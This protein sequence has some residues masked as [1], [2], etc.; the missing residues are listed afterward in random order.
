MEVGD[1]FYLPRK[2]IEDRGFAYK[3]AIYFGPYGLDVGEILNEYVK[4]EITHIKPK[5]QNSYAKIIYNNIKGLCYVEDLFVWF[6][7][8]D[9]L[10]TKEDVINIKR[11]KLEEE[12]K[13]AKEL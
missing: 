4:I 3:Y 2:I 9:K 8:E 13:N 5:G 6:N 12:L 11:Q 7:E 10:L 1:I